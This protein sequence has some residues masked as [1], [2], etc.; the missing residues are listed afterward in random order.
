MV[1]RVCDVVKLIEEDGK[2]DW[3]EGWD[4]SSNDGKE[5]WEEGCDDGLNDG[6]EDYG[7]KDA[8]MIVM[9]VEKLKQ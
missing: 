4:D 2:E 9:M 5:D 8:T 7:K 1:W 6:K 3:E